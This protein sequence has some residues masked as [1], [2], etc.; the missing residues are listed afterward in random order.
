[1][2]SDGGSR[3]TGTIAPLEASRLLALLDI[4]VNEHGVPGLQAAVRFGDGSHW[5]GV[6]GTSD[7]EVANIVPEIER[8]SQ[9]RHAHPCSTR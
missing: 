9:S 4:A 2:N 8:A 1:M 5:T 7:F 6:S 3:G